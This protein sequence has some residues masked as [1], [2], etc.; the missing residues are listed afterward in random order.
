[1]TKTCTKCDTTKPL[2]EFYRSV[3]GRHGRAS[4]C[5][6][7]TRG[8]YRDLY[9]RDPE[10]RKR[11]VENRRRTY[12][13]TK[14]QARRRNFRNKYGITREI[15]DEMSAAQG[16]MCAACG[17]PE[18][19]LVNGEPRALAVDH[20]HETGNVRALLCGGCNRA[21]GMVEESPDRLRRLA[22]YIEFHQPARRAGVKSPTRP[23]GAGKEA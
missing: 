6:K 13:R 8:R 5:I 15:Y 4:A 22:A 23:E 11:Q 2:D 10:Y 18:S 14:E 21:L 9:S 20:D 3:T 7:C 16:G 19:V 12:E 1:M 17:C